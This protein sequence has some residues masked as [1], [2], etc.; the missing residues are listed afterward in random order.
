VSA[1]DF[2]APGLTA[3]AAVFAAAEA[4][5]SESS[6]AAVRTLASGCHLLLSHLL[7]VSDDGPQQLTLRSVLHTHENQIY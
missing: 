1:A 3:A 5:A 4:G 7:Q 2:A 6:S